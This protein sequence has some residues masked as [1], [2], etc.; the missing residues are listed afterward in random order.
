MIDES[1]LKSHFIGRDG[2]RWWIGQIPPIEGSQKEQFSGEGW[3]NRT[4]VRILGYHPYDESEL[5]NEDLP[6]AGILLPSTAGTGASNMATSHKIRPGDIVVGFFLDGD[7]EQLPMII[8]AFGRTKYVLNNEY[9]SPFVPFTGY[10]DNITSDGSK[11]KKNEENERSNTS[12]E[13]PVSLPPS[14]ANSKNKISYSSAIGDDIYFA[15]TKPGSKIDKI[16]TEIENAIKFLDNIKSYPNIAQNWIDDQVEKICEEV[17]SKIKGIVSEIVSGVINDAYEKLIPPLNTG[18][19][20]IYE[21][22]SSTVT[23]A[24]QSKSTGHLAGVEAQAAA[25]AP[26]KELQK[27]IPCIIS[28]IIDL[29]GN[30]ISDMICSI[31]KNVANFVNCVIDQFVGNLLNSIIDLI[32]SGMSAVLGGLSLLLSFTG[33]NLL[34]S[35]KQS[36]TGLLGIPFSFSCGESSENLQDMVDKWKI[37]YGAD[38]LLS[39]SFDNILENANGNLS[40]CYTGPPLSKTLPIVNIFGG[41]GTGADAIPIFGTIDDDTA[42]IIGIVVTSGGSG[43]YYPPFVTVTDSYGNGYGVVAESIIKDGE[44]IAIVINSEGENYT[45]G[46]NPEDLIISDVIIKNPGI[47]YG[48]SDIAID[49]FGNEYNLIIDNGSIIDVIPPLNIK[50]FTND[51][52]I[53]KVI[54]KTGFGANLKPV[55]GLRTRFEQKVE[56]VIDCIL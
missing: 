42:S 22:V 41:G 21:Q 4:K 26:V 1:L 44:V 9:T 16:T 3:G 34:D 46:E 25:I 45:K 11:L 49:N 28:S 32:S 23:S 39:F 43:Y 55:F 10:T 27:L 24:T 13:S 14:I 31:L 52:P 33:F 6:W 37:G 20:Q 47:N 12:Q 15:S 53:I 17:S 2:F 48:N 19:E 29:L 56:Q 35:I 30:I 7:N 36:V 18:A 38:L 50:E 51:L 54:S 8:G 40:E 5:S